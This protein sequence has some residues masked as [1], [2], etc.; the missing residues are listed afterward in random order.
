MVPIPGTGSVTHLEE[1]VAAAGLR[2]S[3]A[4]VE[5]LTAGR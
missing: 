1:N 2:L 4:D 3:G 5:Q